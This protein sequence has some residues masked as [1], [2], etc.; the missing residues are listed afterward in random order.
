MKHQWTE[1]ELVEHF[2]FLP[3]ERQVVEKKRNTT[4]LGFAVLFKYFQQEARFPT[5]P[6]MIPLPVIEFIAKQLQVS[7]DQF[8]YYDWRGRTLERHRAEVR[9]HFGF[10]EHSIQDV[11]DISQW[12]VEKVLDH[13]Q[14][15]ESLK[16][17]VLTTFRQQKIEPSSDRSIYIMIRSS[18]HQH[19]Q[20]FY[21]K[22]VRRLSEVSKK[23]MD[24]SMEAWADMD[25]KFMEET[26]SKEKENLTFSQINMGPGRA[27][28]KTLEWE[29]KKLK[30]LKM[31]ELPNDLFSHIPSKMLRKY[32][33]RAISEKA[34]ERRRHPPEVRY[35]LLSAFFWSRCREITDSLVELLM[36]ITHNINGQAE[37]KVDRELLKEIK[38][39]RG[40]N[41][42]MATLLEE[43]LDNQENVV[44]EILFSVMNEETAQDLLKELKYNKNVYR[45]KVYYKMRSSYSHS[46]RTAITDLL[47]ILEFRSNN[48]KHQPVI[49]A[50]DL[51]KKYIGT[52][53]KYFPIDDD[54][55]IDEVVPS[56]FMKVVLEKDTKG[57]SRVNRI[58]YEI[59]VLQSLR[60]KLRCKE[61][62]V[63]G[64]DRYRDP[65]E[66]LPT[67]F[68]K[69]RQEYY[70]ALDLSMDVDSIISKLQK[71]LDNKLGQL[72]QSVPNDP[73]VSI[74]NYRNGWIS[75]SPLEPQPEPERLIQLKQVVAKRWWLLELIDMF[76]ETDLRTDF[77]GAFHSLARY[78][79]L[80][81]SE[82]Q[83]RLLLCLYGLGTNMGLKRM[84]AGNPDVTYDNLLYVKRKYIHPENLKAANVQVVNAILKERVEDVWGQATTSCASDSKK[85]G[86]WDQNL[87]SQWH[88]RYRGTGVMIYWHVENQSVCFHS[89]LKTCLSSEVASMIQGLLH[90]A[91][92]KEVDRNYVDTHGQSEIGFAFCHLL[93][94][95]L[96][97]RFK[98][99]GR[100]KLYKP[101]HGMTD[102]Y[103]NLQPVMAQKPIDW[104]L[105]RQ[106]YDQMVKYATALKFNT[107]ETEAIL[108]RFSKNKSHP[109]YKAL[110]ELGKAIKTIFL[111][112][113]LMYEEIRQEINEGLNVVENWN[114]AVGFIFFGNSGE[115]QKNQVE[116]QEVA[117][118]S[119]QLL[120]NSLVYINTLKIQN[121]MKDHGWIDK[122]SPND[123]RALSPLIY[124]H[125]TPYGRFEIDL[126]KRLSL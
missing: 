39:V 10:R 57:N 60:D 80:N 86:A 79:R 78:E 87:M 61:I 96:M 64:A 32:R 95:K 70:D 4:R 55:L 123:L 56:K 72:N 7:T 125:I 71:E 28:K 27:S 103:L 43:M 16:E 25:E 49:K 121:T 44:K 48:P 84:A 104:G 22:T 94:F 51:V 97:P 69:K 108:K 21:E 15:E 31:L 76:K 12:L 77:T 115:L 53:Q 11:K 8:R 109:V 14:N 107:A 110:S 54:I 126:D 37:K 23:R 18:I 75:V 24:A 26:R 1:E 85:V 65:E 66:D 6:S 105:I 112:D 34:N 102:A 119:L 40:K 38:R 3:T 120:Q 73:K 33:L 17:K 100:Q 20:I 62:W 89:Q 2:I 5:D 122:M 74:S 59:S 98:N 50:L 92:E 19:E 46:Y 113:Y 117:V 47:S 106:Q 82:I 45:E 67:D 9:Q 63:V 36:T 81:R 88:P 111:C 116:D 68:E 13:N 29:I 52:R 124:N 91:T 35:T 118:L 101:H 30:D 83:K 58:N 42:I 90:H 41:N 93:G 99:I 114:S